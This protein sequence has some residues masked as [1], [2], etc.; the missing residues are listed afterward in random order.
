MDNLEIDPSAVSLSEL[1]YG[2]RDEKSRNIRIDMGLDQ[3]IADQIVVNA[4][5]IRKLC[6]M[7]GIENFEIDGT[8][9]LEENLGIFGVDANGAAVGSFVAS[10]L[11][12]ADLIPRLSVFAHKCCQ[13]V[14]LKVNL[15][16]EELASQ[17]EDDKSAEDWAR[18]L[19]RVVREVLLR[20]GLRHLMKLNKENAVI[21]MA[22][23][24][25][26]SFVGSLFSASVQLSNNTALADPLAPI[27]VIGMSCGITY[28]GINA[29]FYATSPSSR[30]SIINIAGAEIDRAVILS[31]MCLRGRLFDIVNSS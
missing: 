21:L 15:D 11:Y 10:K 28:S 26:G 20:K 1:A 12:E 14:D 30:L 7:A 24:C 25:A 31:A 27:I 8:D 9:S 18:K 2:V 16:K 6:D 22:I 4:A 23:V 17:V 3:E 5:R 29:L 13:T 19:D